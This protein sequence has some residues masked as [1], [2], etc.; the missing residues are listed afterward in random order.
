MVSP[1]CHPINEET[2][3]F[4]LSK[5]RGRRTQY[6]TIQMTHSAEGNRF[7][8]INFT[9]FRDILCGQLFNVAQLC[10]MC[11]VQKKISKDYLSKL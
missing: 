9:N 5:F 6:K 3:F 4:K 10:A 8:K 11:L 7:M 1:T 2:G